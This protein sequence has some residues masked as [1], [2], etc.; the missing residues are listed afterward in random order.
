MVDCL[1]DG[2][3]WIAALHE[4]ILDSSNLALSSSIEQLG[5]DHFSRADAL[6]ARVA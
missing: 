5:G 2:L 3:I 6:P 1:L 4:P